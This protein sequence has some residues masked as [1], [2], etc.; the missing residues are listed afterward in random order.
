MTDGGSSTGGSGDFHGSCTVL[1]GMPHSSGTD[2]RTYSPSG[3][4]CPVVPRRS[5]PPD[6]A[7]AVRGETANVTNAVSGTRAYVV[8]KAAAALGGLVG[9]G[10]L[11]EHVAEDALIDAASVHDGVD[12]WTPREARRHIRNGIARGRNDPRRLDGL[13]A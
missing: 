5:D 10:V 13:T 9:A 6:V 2:Q 11:D 1:P 12:E 8:F 7:A 3:S 4:N